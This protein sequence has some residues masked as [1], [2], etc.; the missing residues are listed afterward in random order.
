M[1][2]GEWT[3]RSY[4]N[5]AKL[6]G[7]DPQTALELIFGEGV[8]QISQGASGYL[9]GTFDMGGGYVLDLVGSSLAHAGS[10]PQ[11]FEFSG[12]GRDAT[13]TEGW[14]YDY[15]GAENHVWPDGEAQVPTL[16]GTDPQQ[17]T[18]RRCSGIFRFLHLH[19]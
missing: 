13:P 14:Q 15:R 4:R 7:G 16:V 5:D 2:N 9:S 18:R 19:P 8:M 17:I 1:L 12:K 10:G 11:G 3:Y 6:V